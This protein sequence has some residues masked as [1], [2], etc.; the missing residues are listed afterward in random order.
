MFN[1]PP[2]DLSTKAGR[3]AWRHEMRMVAVR[4]RRYGLWLLTIG[5]LLIVMPSALGIYSLFG[6]WPPFLGAAAM[7][8]SAPLLIAGVALRRR[9]RR[10]RMAGRSDVA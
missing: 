3:K 8:S 2:P 9:Y 5:M 4:P 10:M 7:L 1:H 6:L